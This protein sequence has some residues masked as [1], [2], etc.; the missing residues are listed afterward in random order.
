V[1]AP[2]EPTA[3]ALVP[4]PYAGAVSRLA[5]YVVDHIAV[6][7][8]FSVG[9]AATAFLVEIVTGRELDLSG[10]VPAG[11]ALAVWWLTYFSVSWA[12][13]GT[14]LGMAL[15]GLRVVRP[16]GTPVGAGRAGLRALAFPLSVAL[17]GLGFLGI[18]VHRQRRA[19]HDLIAG[20][21]VVYD[22][23]RLAQTV[24]GGP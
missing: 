5:A 10:S 18:V 7:L 9:V 13:T 16:N 24:T 4:S 22:E 2:P 15:L 8:L 21:A 23:R 19:L 3:R 6:S 17:I 20:T 14:T 11:T 1:T 12:T